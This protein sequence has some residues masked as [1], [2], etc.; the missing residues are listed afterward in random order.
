[1]RNKY[2][3]WTIPLKLLSTVSSWW[4]RNDYRAIFTIHPSFERL[5]SLKQEN[6]HKNQQNVFRTVSMPPQFSFSGV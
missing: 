6:I 2:D 4:F 5:T 1:M 3:R